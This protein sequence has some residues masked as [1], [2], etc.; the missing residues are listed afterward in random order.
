MARATRSVVL[1]NEHG[2]HARPLKKLVEAARL[3]TARLTICVEDRRADGR[4][5]LEVMTLFAPK[6]SLV[7]FEAD[8]DD[9]E[10]LVAELV[11][12][13]EGGFGED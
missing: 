12:L 13:V 3:R 6:G 7:V 4:K 10:L 8:G 9:A 11:A 2:L 5:L 1:S